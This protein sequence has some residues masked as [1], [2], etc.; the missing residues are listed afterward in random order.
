VA[1]A[2]RLILQGDVT[3]RGVVAPTRPGV[4]NPILDELERLDIRCE[5]RVERT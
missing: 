4:Y 2:T 5:E 1:I 3:E